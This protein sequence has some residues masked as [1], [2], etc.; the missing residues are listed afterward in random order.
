[1]TDNQEEPSLKRPRR[2]RD[3]VPDGIYIMYYIFLKSYSF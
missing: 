3:K 1:M 2:P